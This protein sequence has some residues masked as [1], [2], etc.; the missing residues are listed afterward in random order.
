MDKKEISDCREENSLKSYKRLL[1]RY[2]KFCEFRL[3]IMSERI[4]EKYSDDPI[5]GF[6]SKYSMSDKKQFF[7]LYDKEIFE[8]EL[9]LLIK[10]TN[11]DLLDSVKQLITEIEQSISSIKD[12]DC[13]YYRKAVEGQILFA[14]QNVCKDGALKVW[15][16]SEY[17]GFYK[18]DT[19]LIIDKL[20]QVIDNELISLPLFKHSRYVHF[21]FNTSEEYRR[22]VLNAIISQIINVDY[23]DSSIIQK[24]DYRALRYFELRLL[25]WIRNKHFKSD[26]YY[27]F[28]KNILKEAKKGVH[29]ENI[30]FHIIEILHILISKIKDPQKV[31][32]LILIHK[33]VNGLW[34]NGSKFLHF[35][36]LH[37][38]EHSIALIKNVITLINTIS[39][40]NIKEQDYYLLFL[41][42]Y[43]HDVSMVVYPDLNTFCR[44]SKKSDLIYSEFINDISKY[45]K[46]I[47]YEPK[48]KI[49]HLIID[50]FK[51]VDSYFEETVRSNHTK[52]SATFVKK[53]YNT[54]YFKFIESSILQIV[55]EIAESHGYDACEV[56][57]RKSLAK[58]ELYSLKYMM[59]L[60]RFA[61][62]LDLAKDRVSDYILKEN[63][64]HMSSVSK[65]HWISHYI[66]DKCELK[67][68][69]KLK[70]QSDGG[71]RLEKGVIEEEIVFD[72]Y[73][74]TKQLISIS[75]NCKCSEYVICEPDLTHNKIDIKIPNEVKEGVKLC[76]AQQ[77]SLLCKWI[78][79]KHEYLFSEIYEL[80]R[81]LDSVNTGLFTTNITVRINY[82]NIQTLEPKLLD[83]VVAYLNNYM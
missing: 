12:G 58:S 3:K 6:K 21:I 48:S 72:L 64:D 50:Y 73:I 36:T 74:N 56:Y 30:D 16:Q 40:L 75:P 67:A 4:V 23:S 29:T 25:I 7:E 61:D 62:L 70:S 17:K 66:T 53:R 52:D 71:I 32:D 27:L 43:L 11:T 13:L 69:F 80:V 65:F 22:R 9:S 63:I 42:C 15:T 34:K 10:H 79:V 76:C 44:D 31:D 1:I 45:N 14:N 46:A 82:D 78:T 38:E 68:N 47:E 60:I 57:G 24:R 5:E 55:T 37:N 33:L 20:I 59:I 39:Y 83:S 51:K 28:A 8:A 19:N 2:R 41:A 81:Y 77:C 49:K 35:Y 18:R 26:V 54:K